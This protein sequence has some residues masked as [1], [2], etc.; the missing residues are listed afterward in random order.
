MIGPTATGTHLQCHTPGHPVTPPGR[1]RGTCHPNQ[2][3][4]PGSKRRLSLFTYV[5]CEYMFLVE[6]ASA[7]DSEWKKESYLFTHTTGSVPYYHG[8]LKS[9]CF[10][11][12]IS[13][14]LEQAFL[15]VRTKR[16]LVQLITP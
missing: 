7:P 14:G 1:W 16:W 3:A 12:D 5:Y 6:P 2:E 10:D 9:I 15:R 11:I 8:T 13:A 4:Q